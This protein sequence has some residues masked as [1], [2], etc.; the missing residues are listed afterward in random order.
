MPGLDWHRA[1][2]PPTLRASG[3]V[4]L[5]KESICQLPLATPAAA[6]T[7]HTQQ[8]P[9]GQLAARQ[10]ERQSQLMFTKHS[11][12]IITQEPAM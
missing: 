3:G 5:K 4:M 8:G 10:R 1:A 11:L 12:K 6:G 7:I 2:R 9:A